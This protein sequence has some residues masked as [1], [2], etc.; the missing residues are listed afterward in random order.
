MGIRCMALRNRWSGAV[1]KL[2]SHLCTCLADEKF[3][4]AVVNPGF[5]TGPLLS[6]NPCTSLEVSHICS[7]T[8]NRV[9]MLYADLLRAL[10][11]VLAM[12]KCGSDLLVSGR[13]CLCKPPSC[14]FHLRWCHS[15]FVFQVIKRIME[16][17]D[18]ATVKLHFP[19]VDVRD[20]A[21]AHLAAM[22]VP[23]A[24]G[25]RHI[26]VSGSLWMQDMARILQDEFKQQGVLPV[27]WG[28]RHIFSCEIA[29]V[30]GCRC[31]Q[32]Q[33]WRHRHQRSLQP[34]ARLLVPGVVAFTCVGA[35]MPPHPQPQQQH[36]R[37][38]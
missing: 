28:S 10:F 1:L 2:E 8:N 12:Q 31:W 11:S 7:S 25:H 26:L 27:S 33:R 17:K 9:M 15:S 4:M 14:M 36:A 37:F 18:P 38:L 24:A 19:T 6:T 3:E 29:M 5:V 22:T 34:V 32:D 16:H 20:V 13:H 21:A 35:P 30:N 23:G